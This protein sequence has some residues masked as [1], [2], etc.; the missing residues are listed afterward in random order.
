MKVS[1]YDYYSHDEIKKIRSFTEDEIN[2]MS[3]VKF[4]SLIKEVNK[5]PGGLSYLLRLI[6]MMGI[7]ERSSVLD[8]GCNTGYVSFEVS[9]FTKCKVVG[10]DI[11]K[12]MIRTANKIKKFDSFKKRIVFKVADAKNLPFASNTFDFIIVGGSLAFIDDKLMALKEFLRVLKPWGLIGDLEF[13]YKR[14]PP[15]I[16][17][18]KL[19]ETLE[20][21]IEPWNY[22]FWL[23]LYENAGFEIV[24][25]EIMNLKMSKT[26]REIENYCRKIIE[27]VPFKNGVKRVAFKKL[28]NY[29]TLFN[30]N[31]KLLDGI[32][33]IARKR[34]YPEQIFLFSK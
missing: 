31:N 13:F 6:R 3:Y 22:N 4:I 8:V 23:K 28:L 16:L 9:H 14:N 25:Y 33:I 5:P 17:L 18:R 21:R 34:E 20:I 26:Y 1:P 15:K 2:R 7:S 10:I 19:K 29:M 32:M 27:R 12:D 11:D 24:Y 30:E